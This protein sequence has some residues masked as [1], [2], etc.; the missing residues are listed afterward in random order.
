MT[1]YP[2][3]LLRLNDNL[4]ILRE[5]EAKYAG[6]TPPELLNQIEDH[7]T[8]I[9]LTERAI[10]GQLSETE[11]RA[12]LKPLLVAINRRGGEAAVVIGDV[13]GGIHGSIIARGDVKDG[14]LFQTDDVSGSY[15][16]IGHGASP[17]TEFRA[18]FNFVGVV[19]RPQ[20]AL[21]RIMGCRLSFL[22]GV[23]GGG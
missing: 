20:P 16:V 8:A 11:W 1:A 19:A 2:Q 6:N 23:G 5:R 21:G 13:T 17:P 7:Q 10:A 9:T 3:I 18:L 15:N 4:N 12:T 22:N 14:Q